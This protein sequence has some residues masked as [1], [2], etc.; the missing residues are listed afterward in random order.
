MP[1]GP[2]DLRIDRLWLRRLLWLREAA[3]SAV[4]LDA[5]LRTVEIDARKGASILM[6]GAFSTVFDVPTEMWSD[7]VLSRV[8]ERFAELNR[9]AFEQG[10]PRMREEKL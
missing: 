10:K 4:F 1:S 5:T 2:S 3:A 7:V 6:L 9:K 8:P